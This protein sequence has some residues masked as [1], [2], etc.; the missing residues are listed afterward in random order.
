M[1]YNHH[2]EVQCVPDAAR[3]VAAVKKLL[4]LE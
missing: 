4:Y 2:L 3:A 1:P